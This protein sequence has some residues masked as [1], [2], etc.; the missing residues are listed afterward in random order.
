MPVT[1]KITLYVFQVV[2]LKIKV[3]STFNSITTCSVTQS[4]SML[5]RN[6]LTANF[7]ATIHFSEEFFGSDFFHL[8]RYA[9][10]SR[11]LFF[12]FMTSREHASIVCG[13]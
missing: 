6:I 11:D 2:F 3:Y 7:M 4:T 1:G 12:H 9:G 5:L 13:T 8:T 10:D